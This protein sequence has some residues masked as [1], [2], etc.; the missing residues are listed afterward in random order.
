MSN[1]FFIFNYFI[2]R[3]SLDNALARL[4][5]TSENVYTNIALNTF[6]KKKNIIEY[7]MPA[8]MNDSSP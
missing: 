7:A 4:R 2:T 3:Y 8:M 1:V 6:S 5:A